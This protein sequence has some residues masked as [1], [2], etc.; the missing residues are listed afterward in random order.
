MMGSSIRQPVPPDRGPATVVGQCPIFRGVSCKLVQH[1]RRGL[2]GFRLKG[3]VW[4]ADFRIACAIGCKLAPDD[5][6]KRYAVPT[7]MA[8]QLVGSRQRLDAVI[9]RSHEVGS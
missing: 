2:S 6:Q 5:F 3:Y 4:T 1:H 8:Q 7:A 9:D